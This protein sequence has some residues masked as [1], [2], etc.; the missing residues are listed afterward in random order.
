MSHPSTQIWQPHVTVAV[1]VEQKGKFL[2]VEE[3]SNGNMVFNQP[4]GHLEEHET[5]TDAAVRETCEETGWTIKI[6]GIVG[7]SLHVS[8]HNQVTYHRTTFFGEVVSHNPDQPLDD[9]IKRALWMTYE[10][11]LEERERMR[12]E[13]VIKTVEQYQDGHFYPLGLMFN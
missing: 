11:M 9:G 12:S 13:L 7:V 8:P 4:A 3:M 5:L 1:V 6:T 2:L 10:E